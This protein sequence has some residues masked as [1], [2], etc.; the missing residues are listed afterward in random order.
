MPT[1]N[2]NWQGGKW[3]RPATRLAIY[4]RDGLACLW[5]GEGVEHGVTLSLD[6]FHTVKKTGE[7]DNSPTNL[8]TSCTRCN[9]RRGARTVTEFA[10]GVAAYVNGGVTP[11]QI[12]KGI[13]AA[14]KRVLPREQAREILKL[15]GTVRAALLSTVSEN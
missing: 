11:E 6:H 3:C 15:R 9:S 7:A 14:R 12:L 4:L 1:R 2:D 10:R 13:N 5:C 8:F